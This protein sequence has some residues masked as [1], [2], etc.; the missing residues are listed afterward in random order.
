MQ[1]RTFVSVSLLVMLFCVVKGRQ[2]EEDLSAKKTSLVWT[3]CFFFFSGDLF[4]SPVLWPVT[5]C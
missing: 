3:E 4:I 5:Y 2:C 1:Y